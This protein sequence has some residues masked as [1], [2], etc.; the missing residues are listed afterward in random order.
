MQPGDAYFQKKS[1]PP[2]L[3]TADSAA[4]NLTPLGPASYGGTTN[5]LI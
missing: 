1:P 4:A 2:N 5:R 3:S